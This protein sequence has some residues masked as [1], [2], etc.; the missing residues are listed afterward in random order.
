M[1]LHVASC[2]VANCRTPVKTSQIDLY[3]NNLGGTLHSLKTVPSL[4][5]PLQ[6]TPIKRPLREREGIYDR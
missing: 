6:L 1:S 4:T 2:R 5:F 3:Y